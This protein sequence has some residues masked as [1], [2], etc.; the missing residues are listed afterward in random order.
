MQINL[1]DVSHSFS[2]QP[3]LFTHVTFSICSGEMVAIVGPSGSGKSTLLSILA[4]WQKPSEGEV[5]RSGIESISWVFQNPH[6]VAQRS[7]LDHVSLPLLARGL[8]R[9]EADTEARRILEIFGLLELSHRPFSSL[10]GG[11]AQ[12]LMLSRAVAKKPSVLL[13]DEPTAQLDM[14][15][16]KTVNAVLSSLSGIDSI[17][18]VAT[19]DFHTRDACSRVIDLNDFIIDE[20]S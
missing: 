3:Q 6:G 9:S 11:E 18:V 10:S 19:H 4:G 14:A 1:T 16:A 2:G 20:S 5:L 13:V 7:A 17:V 8:G 12:R 15:S